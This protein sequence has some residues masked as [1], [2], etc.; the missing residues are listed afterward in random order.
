[1][2]EVTQGAIELVLDALE[3]EIR[4]QDEKHGPFTG[5]ELGKTRLAIACLEDE[6]NEALDEW[7]NERQHA[8]WDR[9]R[10]EIIQV[11]AVAIRAVRDAFL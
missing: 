5:T 8:T 6:V 9:T 1:M 10:T 7:R 2:S 4:R 3:G 11:A